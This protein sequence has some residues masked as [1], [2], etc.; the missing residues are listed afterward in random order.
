MGDCLRSPAH[1]S[2][3]FKPRSRAPSFGCRIN[4]M[5]LLAQSKFLCEVIL[6]Q[7]DNILKKTC[8]AVMLWSRKT[9]KDCGNSEAI[10]NA[11]CRTVAI[12][13]NELEIA[14]VSGLRIMLMKWTNE[15]D[16]RLPFV[17]ITSAKEWKIARISSTIH[18]VRS[19][20]VII[21]R[22]A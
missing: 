2:Y 5:L 22:T 21:T 15:M 8:N 13:Y 18:N 10:S 4:T 3:Y 1:I 11:H 9:V 7:T 6:S 19:S 16:D 17:I 12:I 14:I 20:L